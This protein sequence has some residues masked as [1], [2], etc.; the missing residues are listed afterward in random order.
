M[1][2][3]FK[4]FTPP[5]NEYGMITRTQQELTPTLERALPRLSKKKISLLAFELVG[6]VLGLRTATLI[7]SLLLTEQD[8]V[9]LA[10]ALSE[11]KVTLLVVYEPVSGQA[12]IVNRDLLKDRVQQRAFFV[13]VGGRAPVLLGEKPESFTLLLDRISSTPSSL[14]FLALSLPYQDRP[15]DLIPLIG[16]LLD[17]PVAYCLGESEDGRN[18]LGGIE[19]TLVEGV[20]LDEYGESYRL[21]SFSYPTQLAEGKL[22]PSSVCHKMK[23]LLEDRL[24]RVERVDYEEKCT[25]EVET[26]IVVLDQVAL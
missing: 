16:Y 22:S 25:V 1:W 5:S 11:C 20:L 2:V 14:N 8:T 4:P 3:D 23:D 18:C 17:Y 15:Q 9:V 19:L 26:R 6:I 21:L 24:R 12:F 7:D 10:D 13:D